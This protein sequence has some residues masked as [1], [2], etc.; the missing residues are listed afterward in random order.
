MM[1]SKIAIIHLLFIIYFF[2][3]FSIFVK[4]RD[5]EKKKLTIYL[6]I[7]FFFYSITMI[8]YLLRRKLFQYCQ[9]ATTT[10]LYCYSLSV[11]THLIQGALLTNIVSK[12]FCQT[13]NT[14]EMSLFHLCYF[15]WFVL[16]GGMIFFYN[17]QLL[18]S[19]LE[20]TFQDPLDQLLN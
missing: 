4:F 18:M 11:L 19:C 6:G 16:S 3:C 5:S 20:L 2:L 1:I 14:S 9:I 10:F 13:T 15:I 17:F 8:I 12:F 7:E